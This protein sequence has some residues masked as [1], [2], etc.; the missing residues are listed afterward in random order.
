LDRA[1]ARSGL[2][3]GGLST[4]ERHRRLNGPGL[5]IRSGLFAFR[6]RSDVAAIDRAVATLYTDYPCLDESEFC[7][8]ALDLR[9]PRSLRRWLR[10]KITALYDGEPVFES[11]PAGHAFPLMEWS[12][13]YCISSHAFEH[14]SL[15]AAVVERGGRAVILP[16]PPGSGKSTLCA[17][18]IHRGWRLLSDEMTLVSLT[19]GCVVP[20][21]RPV[22]L[23]NR[24]IEIM[25]AFAPEA[26]FCDPTHD[27]LK[28]TVAHMRAPSA[29]VRRMHEPA[30]PAW[31]VFPRW[32][33]DAP[34]T[35]RERP[36]PDTVLEL[37]RNSF[38]L[39]V[40][41]RAGFECLT[42]LVDRSRCFDFTYGHLDDAMQVFDDLAAT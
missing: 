16:A 29:H 15:H 42:S 3:V 40:L 6:L 33:A 25:S 12:L 39:T 18:L 36:K 24:S 5:A 37:G 8:F 19:D 4:A 41:G 28:G 2:T 7:D 20:I 23:K 14:L 38:N 21:A 9:R 35:L 17:A 26:V 13:N 32:Q 27:T 31:I 1:G 10:P 22:S 30:Q 34:A 11:L